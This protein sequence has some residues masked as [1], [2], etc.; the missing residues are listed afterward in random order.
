MLA[1]LLAAMTVMAL[2]GGARVLGSLPDVGRDQL[3]EDRWAAPLGVQKAGK[4]QI[5]L[6]PQCASGA[7]SRIVLWDAN[8]NP[9]WEVVGPSTPLDAFVVG[10]TPNRFYE[11]KAYRPPSSGTVVRLV[12]F[13]TVGGPVGLRYRAS[14]LREGRAV[15][16]DPPARFTPAGFRTARVC[17]GA[18]A[19]KREG[20]GT[21]S[22]TTTTLPGSAG[23]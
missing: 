14:D 11:I 12:A 1:G 21:G 4:F 3:G 7:V 5:G 10:Q 6:I 8:S 17:P 13:R 16:G 19:T 15:S 20:D 9:Y 18:G 23:N 2:L 22:T